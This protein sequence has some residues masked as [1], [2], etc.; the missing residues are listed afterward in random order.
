MSFVVRRTT[1][2]KL[3]AP[4]SPP[5]RLFP[6]R[7]ET[8]PAGKSWKG[9]TF[10]AEGEEK[11]TTHTNGERDWKRHE[12]GNDSSRRLSL[13]G[14]HSTPSLSPFPD[15]PPPF[16]RSTHPRPKY[17]CA[18]KWFGRVRPPRR[19][20]ESSSSCPIPSFNFVLPP[21]LF[22]LFPKTPLFSLTVAGRD[23]SDGRIS[24][25]LFPSS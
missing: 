23:P 13:L 8:E 3:T 2:V 14:T 17:A 4:H 5:N 15:F 9:A 20:I 19:T 12:G 16:S 1:T 7:N 11:T 18:H 10:L 21:L 22:H 25:S 6:S 24:L